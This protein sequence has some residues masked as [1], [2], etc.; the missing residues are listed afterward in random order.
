MDLHHGFSPGLL[1]CLAFLHL[2]TLGFVLGEYVLLMYDWIATFY[3]SLSI[4]ALVRTYHIKG[5]FMDLI[6]GPLFI[7]GLDLKRILNGLQGAK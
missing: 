5:I 4:N 6:R 7:L 2:H 1:S 3:I